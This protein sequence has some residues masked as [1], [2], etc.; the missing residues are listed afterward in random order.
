MRERR[1]PTASVSP[2]LHLCVVRRGGVVIRNN[3]APTFFSDGRREDLRMP[4][5]AAT[6]NEFEML[7]G[8]QGLSA[9]RAAA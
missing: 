1:L 3:D 9:V 5:D 2:H 6:W 7:C 8:A 4:P